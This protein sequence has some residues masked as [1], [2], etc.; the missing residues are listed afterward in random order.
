MDSP[1]RP[2]LSERG[3]QMVTPESPTSRECS[4]GMVCSSSRGSA[5]TSPSEPHTLA[6]SPLGKAQNH[7][8]GK[9]VLQI[10]PE[11]P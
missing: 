9:E 5:L 8:S 6:A 7:I 2:G 3:G 10:M 11:L 4:V 1:R